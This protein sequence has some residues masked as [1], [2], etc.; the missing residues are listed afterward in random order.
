MIC[1]TFAFGSSAVLNPL[2]LP[3]VFSVQSEIVISLDAIEEKIHATNAG[4]KRRSRDKTM[5]VP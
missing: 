3:V 2:K 1:I 4:G 5:E